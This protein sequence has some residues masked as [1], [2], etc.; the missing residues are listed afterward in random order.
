M[1]KESV[2]GKTGQWWKLGIGVIAMLFGSIAPL[3]DST[4]ISIMT[5][6]VIALAG[7]GFSIA[8]ISCP[9]CQLRWFW[10]ALIYSE[11]YKPLFT[12]S[13]CPNCEYEF[14]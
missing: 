5:G 12:K 6:T 7:Y 8:F 3:M 4:G 10:K 1:F 2:I 9:Q 11:L 14:G 13:T